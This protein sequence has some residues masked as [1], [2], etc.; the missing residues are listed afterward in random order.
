LL[1]PGI[2]WGK[3][4]NGCFESVL[5]LKSISLFLDDMDLGVQFFTHVIE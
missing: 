5:V 4:V 2:T 1:L 3:K